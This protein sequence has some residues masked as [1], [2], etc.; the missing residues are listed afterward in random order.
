M[1]PLEEKTKESQRSVTDK[2]P[3]E[4]GRLRTHPG[5]SGPDEAAGTAGS[6]TRFSTLLEGDGEGEG[7]AESLELVLV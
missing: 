3:G 2:L 6:V 4:T 7:A 1:A 5:L